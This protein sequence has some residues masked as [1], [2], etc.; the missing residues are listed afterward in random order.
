MDHDIHPPCI[1]D[2]YRDLGVSQTTSL[3]MIR[4]A[5][6]KL[7]LATHPDKNQ[8]KGTGQSND[9][10]GF[11]KVREAYEHLS[12]PETRASYDDRYLY[13]QAEWERYREQQEGQ[14][15]R[16][17]ERLTKEKAEGERKAAKSERLRK[18][19]EYRKAAE[20]RLRREK[21]REERARQ[22]KMRSRDVARKAW[23]KHQREAEDRIR[24]Q[25]QAVA[26]ARSE[27]VAK[28]MRAE[29]EKAALQRLK[30]AQFQEKQVVVV[31]M[32]FL[33]L[34]NRS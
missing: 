30:L 22:A 1:P 8:N 15:R 24:L 7:A 13:I 4:K 14:S 20:E 5:F 18:L 6:R 27:E 10:A 33:T 25:K 23:E 11:R 29:Q 9:A 12:D 26:E 19:E 2:Y 17:Q 21:L 34:E 28:R 16:E 31:V 32:E 3:A